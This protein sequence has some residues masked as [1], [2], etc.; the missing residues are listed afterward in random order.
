VKQGP[1]DTR[2]PMPVAQTLGTVIGNAVW[3]EM[4]LIRH[5]AMMDPMHYQSD[6]WTMPKVRDRLKI[7]I[8]TAN[9]IGIK[10]AV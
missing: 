4:R 6:F 5:P 1:D 8:C 2:D 3:T 9:D 10:R 7:A